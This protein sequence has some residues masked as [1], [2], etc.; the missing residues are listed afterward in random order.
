M[1]SNLK[2]IYGNRCSGIKIN[3]EGIFVNS[4]AKELP[5]CEAISY[6]FNVPLLVKNTNIPCIGSR[7]S[8]GLLEYENELVH[9]L[10]KHSKVSA[11][12]I[13]K[14]L[15][16][17][18]VISSPF[19]NI[20]LGIPENLESKIQPDLFIIYMKPKDAMEL[21]QLYAAKTDKFPVI[22]PYTFL[23]VCGNIIAQT[24]KKKQVNVSFGCTE[25]RK[26]GS[27]D[28]NMIIVGL[29][30]HIGSLLFN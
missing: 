23:S 25:S 10:H 11:E 26:H 20:F 12:A 3:Y 22:K 27:I 6:S 14:A 8:L 19:E 18:P 24:Y 21:V 4:P 15:K 13:K 2:S 7:R 5:L 9:Y 16:D 28:D 29:P 17:I 30:F 1:I